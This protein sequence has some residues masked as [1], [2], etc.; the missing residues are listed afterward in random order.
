MSK[1]APCAP[2]E[3]E[4]RAWRVWLE[5]R[6]RPAAAIVIIA[7]RSRCGLARRHCGL[8]RRHCGLARR[9]YCL[10]RRPELTE[11]R[12]D[13]VSRLAQSFIGSQPAKNNLLYIWQA[14]VSSASG[15]RDLNSPSVRAGQPSPRRDSLASRCEASPYLCGSC[16]GCVPA[17]ESISQRSRFCHPLKPNRAKRAM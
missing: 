15:N 10:A 6:H 3:G 5:D 12:V 2:P 8:A 7:A 13:L 4:E 16:G 11:P 1:P 17:H 14:I 9:H